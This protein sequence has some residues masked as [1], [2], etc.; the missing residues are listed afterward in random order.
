MRKPLH[1]ACGASHT[2]VCTG[3]LN[4]AYFYRWWRSLLLGWGL[5]R[6][7]RNRQTRKLVHTL[8][9]LLP[10]GCRWCIHCTNLLWD[11]SFS[12]LGLN[13]TIIYLWTW[14]IWLV[15]PWLDRKADTSQVSN[16]TSRKNQNSSMWAITYSCPN[17]NSGTRLFLGL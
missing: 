12:L 5:L 14:R 4:V 13:G 11:K 16:Q 17:S 7:S 8:I 3:K 9:H 1:I 2:L 6:R 10:S 15:R